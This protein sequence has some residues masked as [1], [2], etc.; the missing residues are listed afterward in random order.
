[1]DLNISFMRARKYQ[2]NKLEKY[3]SV[4]TLVCMELLQELVMTP[5][6]HNAPDITPPTTRPNDGDILILSW[7]FEI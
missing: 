4:D 1:M 2:S 6:R 3:R 5:P 7:H